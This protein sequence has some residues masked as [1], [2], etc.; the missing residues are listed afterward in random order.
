MRLP[1]GI[2]S[3]RSDTRYTTFV[4][5]GQP[6]IGNVGVSAANLAELAAA[7]RSVS[8]AAENAIVVASRA[9][10]CISVEQRL[11]GKLHAA[12]QGVAQQL[13]AELADERRRGAS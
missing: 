2:R 13:A 7:R 6:V 9:A 1:R 12:A 3:V 5:R 11:V 10:C 8:T 4:E